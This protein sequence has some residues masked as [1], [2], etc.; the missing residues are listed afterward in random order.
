MSSKLENGVFIYQKTEHTDIVERS[1]KMGVFFS[2]FDF[3]TKWSIY[4]CW[5]RNFGVNWWTDLIYCSKARVSLIY[6]C[7]LRF[8]HRGISSNRSCSIPKDTMDVDSHQ[9]MEETILVG[10][11]LMIG[12]PS[13][14]IPPQITSHVLEGV[15]LC[16]GILRNLFLCLQINDIEPFCQDETA[17]YRKCAERRDI[18][19]RQRLQE[20]GIRSHIAGETEEFLAGL[21]LLSCY[22][23]IEESFEYIIK[24]LSKMQ[25]S[26]FSVHLLALSV[27]QKVAELET[28]SK[29][30]CLTALP[31]SMENLTETEDQVWDERYMISVCVLHSIMIDHLEELNFIDFSYRL[32]KKIPIIM[33]MER[34]TWKEENKSIR[35]AVVDFF[36]Y[37][38]FLRPGSRLVERFHILIMVMMREMHLGDVVVSK[39]CDWMYSVD[40]QELQNYRSIQNLFDFVRGFKYVDPEEVERRRREEEE[41]RKRDE[42]RRVDD[43]GGGVLEAGSRSQENEEPQI[44]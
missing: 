3:T 33:V 13:P 40:V 23:I 24:Q 5:R 6:L 9:T 35:S 38:S 7:S 34:E 44:P 14:L 27:H 18:E 15:D 4:F 26:G 30:W 19:L 29:S 10:D 31:S 25:K 8:T 39:F 43:G 41:R 16:D 2:Q 1:N 20:I 37:C 11:D 21:S 17:L 32:K 42:E 12:P 28:S 22:D 36:D